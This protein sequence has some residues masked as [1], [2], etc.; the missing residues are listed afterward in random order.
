MV[1]PRVNVEP[2][3]DVVERVRDEVQPF[4]EAVSEKIFRAGGDEVLSCVQLSR[5]KPR[6]KKE[7]GGGGIHLLL[8]KS[9]WSI[10]RTRL[11]TGVYSYLVSAI[12]L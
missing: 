4:P 8:A 5:H 3:L 6:Q 1:S 10:D 2:S 12:Y 11:T 7:G 9:H